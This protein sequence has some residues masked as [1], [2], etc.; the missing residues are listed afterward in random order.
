MCNTSF[1][2]YEKEGGSSEAK[3]RGYGGGCRHFGFGACGG[4][5][6]RRRGLRGNGLVHEVVAGEVGSEKGKEGHGN[7]RLGQRGEAE[8]DRRGEEVEGGQAQ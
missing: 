2:G 5:G 4:A 7:C 3:V 1:R 8:D 6:V